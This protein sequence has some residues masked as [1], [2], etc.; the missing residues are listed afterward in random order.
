MRLFKHWVHGGGVSSPLI[1]HWPAQIPPPAH[2][3]LRRQPGHL[4]DIMAT[5][6]DVAGGRYP[7]EYNGN[8][9]T[10]LEG[11]SLVPAFADRGIDRDAIFWEHEGNKAVLVHP[12]KLVSKHPG[13][14]ELYNL[15]LDRGETTDLAKSNP[16]RAQDLSARWQSWAE[17]S[18]VL[19]LRPY[20]MEKKK[21]KDSD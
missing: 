7:T 4:I 21:A 15:E 20:V 19:P 3:Q 10:P 13:P 8:K 5:C 9:I 12:W 14:W 18:H 16:Q 1:A 2:G 11:K 6:V 17:R